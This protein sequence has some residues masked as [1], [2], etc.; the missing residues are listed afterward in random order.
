MACMPMRPVMSVSQ[1]L[2]TRALL[3]MLMAVQGTTPKYSSIEVQHWMAVPASSCSAM[4]ASRTTANLAMR[5]SDSFG[6]LV[7]FTYWRISSSF[8][9]TAESLSLRFHALPKISDRSTLSTEMPA[10]SSS[11]SL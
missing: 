10:R 1:A 3:S 7:A 4:C 5:S 9:S 11:F 8:D 6:I 2:G